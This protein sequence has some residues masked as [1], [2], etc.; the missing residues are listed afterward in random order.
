MTDPSLLLQGTVLVSATQNT[1][2]IQKM[3]FFDPAIITSWTGSPSAG[4]SAVT[5]VSLGN[6][7]VFDFYDETAKVTATVKPG[8]G[9]TVVVET[10]I[11]FMVPNLTATN[12]TAIEG[13]AQFAQSGLVV[14]YTD[15]TGSYWL[16]GTGATPAANQS[17]KMKQ[18]LVSSTGTTSD[19]LDGLAGETVKMMA[20]E[21]Y[22]PIKYTGA[23][24]TDFLG[25]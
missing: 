1:G 12:R 2:G 11:D 21:F 10:E 22:K 14:C 24:D 17:A 15:M 4:Y 3:Y 5:L 7:R 19:T 18:K 25:H 8:K 20:R 13:L 23:P 16:T 9:G 6:A